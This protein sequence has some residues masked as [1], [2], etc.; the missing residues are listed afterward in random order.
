M[1][2]CAPEKWFTFGFLFY[3]KTMRQIFLLVAF[4]AGSTVQAQDAE[5]QGRVGYANIEYIISLMPEI[6]EIEADMKS[7]QTQLRN[8]IQTRSQEVEKQYTD[9]NE[10]MNSMPDTVRM[11]RQRDLERAMAEVE[12]M[13]Q[14]AQQTLQNKQKLYMAPLYLKV[15]RAIGEVAQEAGYTVILT[16][17]IGDYSLLLFQDKQRDISDL[18]LNKFGVTPP[19]K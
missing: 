13:Q 17:R 10:N 6:K 9:F 18:V 4:I 19:A 16:E 1:R 11:N 15:N 14:D 5:P 8:Q 12:Q 3:D 2:F 7:T